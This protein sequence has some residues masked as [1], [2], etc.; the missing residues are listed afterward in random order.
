V[1]RFRLGNAPP[2]Y[3][4]VLTAYRALLVGAAIST[5]A[6]AVAAAAAGGRQSPATINALM[7]MLMLHRYFQP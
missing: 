5:E 7:L 2:Q 1:R 3:C 6:A 4:F